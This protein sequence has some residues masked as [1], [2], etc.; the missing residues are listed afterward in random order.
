MRGLPEAPGSGRAARTLGTRWRG[1][2]FAL[3]AAGL[4]MALVAGAATPAVAGGG[5]VGDPQPELTHFRVGASGG[6]GSGAVL[7]NGNLVLA[8][9]SKTATTITVC[10]LHPGGRSCASTATLS[11]NK[12]GGQDTFYGTVEVVAFG[13]SNVAV[14]ALDCCN[15]GPDGAVIFDSADGGRTFSALKKAGT[16]ASIGAATFA[17]GSVVVG[18]VSQGGLQVQ[19]LAPVPSTPQMSYAVP[20]GGVDGN[21]SLATYHGGVL[22]ASVNTKTTYVE[23]AKAGSGLN[24]TASYTRVGT[25]PNEL[26][27]AVSG[28]ALLTDPGGSLTGGERLRFFNGTSFGQP[29]R[30][31]DA[32][33]G[34]D[35]YFAMQE[36]GSTAH[37]FFLGRRN[38]YDVFE[39][40][41]ANG[42]PWSPLREFGAAIAS[43]SLMPV[44]GPT[45]A[46]VLYATAG[47]PLLAQ[48]I[49][50]AQSVRAVFAAPRVKA[51]RTGVL[52]A[53]TSPSF[54]KPLVVTLEQL[55][56][57]RWYPVRSIRTTTA[58]IRFN[59]PGRTATYRVVVNLIPGYYEYGYS[60]AA[61]LTAV[62]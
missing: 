12:V 2:A 56:S 31:P 6:N 47:S 7:P 18:S 11:A 35:G 57:G 55:R 23:Y 29:I 48:P 20:V 54:S 34:D 45:G 27:T 25:F 52:H 40:N 26:V 24:T 22:V 33:L 14:V 32:R 1:R 44:L 9:P 17:G 53:Y 21:T 60:N 13:G 51:G 8:T 43:T 50:N 61:T 49:L 28:N 15:I 59:V 39:E 16:I 30:V 19:A 46:G 36:T 62:P 3:G 5:T 42:H 37:V 10:V 41:K 58:S 4:A 38:G